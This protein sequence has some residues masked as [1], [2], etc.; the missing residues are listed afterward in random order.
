[1]KVPE[2]EEHYQPF[3]CVFPGAQHH[4]QYGFLHLDINNGIMLCFGGTITPGGG[5][6]VN[7]WHNVTLPLS[8]T[9]H[10]RFVGTYS[11][12]SKGFDSTDFASTNRTRSSLQICLFNSH[13]A[14][15][16]QYIHFVTMGY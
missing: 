5:R 7:I 15:D 12:N 8:Y 2:Q 4:T 6:S 11:L 1:M 14:F 3:Q 16:P 10:F 9:N 13:F